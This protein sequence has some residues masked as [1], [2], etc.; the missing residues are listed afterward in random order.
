MSGEKW[1][2][3]SGSSLLLDSCA[4]ISYFKDHVGVTELLRKAEQLHLPLVVYGEL[5][6]GALK[7][8]N[9]SRRLREL[10]EFLSIVTLIR[11]NQETAEIYSEIRLQ[12][13]LIGKPI[14]ENDLWIAATAKQYE[15]PVMTNDQHF[16]LIEGVNL[17]WN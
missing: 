15:L 4:V 13:S 17:I 9:S 1:N 12:L 16:K 6:F 3:R 2:M 10:E 14:P 5:Y 8:R 11:P 7:A